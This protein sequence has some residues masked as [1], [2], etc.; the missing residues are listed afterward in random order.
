[1]DRAMTKLKPRSHSDPFTAEFFWSRVDKSGGPDACWPWMLSRRGKGYGQVCIGNRRVCD[2]HRVAHVLAVGPIPDGH[3]VCHSCDNPPCCNPAHLWIGTP[4][5]NVRDMMRKGRRVWRGLP[6][7][8]NPRAR[9]SNEQVRAI[10]KMEGSGVSIAKRFGVHPVTISHIR[11]G[12][13]WK[14]V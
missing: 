8:T 1:M 10:R 9:L 5:D 4:D 2:T 13:S 12:R 6:G 11:T 3:F 7:Q 14:S